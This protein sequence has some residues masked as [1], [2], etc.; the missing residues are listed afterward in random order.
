MK[1]LTEEKNDYLLDVLLEVENF[2]QIEQNWPYLYWRGIV[3]RCCKVRI[4][5]NY[6][7]IVCFHRINRFVS[8][9][10]AL[11]HVSLTIKIAIHHLHCKK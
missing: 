10:T 11:Q 4:L 9:G 8:L 6:L 3:S 5:R 2:R 7:G 1:P